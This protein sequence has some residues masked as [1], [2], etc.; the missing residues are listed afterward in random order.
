MPAFVAEPLPAE[1]VAEPA[2]RPILIIE[3][4]ESIAEVLSIRLEQQGYGA[5][6]AHSG[7]RGLAL[8]Q[9]ISPQ[10][11]LLDLELPDMDGLAVCQQLDENP[12][13]VAIPKIILSGRDGGDIVRRAR[14]AGCQFYVRKP[15]D[16][17]ALL[18]L[19]QQAIR[20]A[21]EADLE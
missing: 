12:A 17:N 6:I 1:T 13:T 10:L 7:A 5:H 20:D 3:D 19:I 15:Y 2:P 8:A 16:P 21:F 18:V 9:S 4:D 11:V 14:A